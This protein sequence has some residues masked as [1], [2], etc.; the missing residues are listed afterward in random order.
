MKTN[1]S[2]EV[3]IDVALV[4]RAVAWFTLTCAIIIEHFRQ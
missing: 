4:I 3:K 1:L 2:I